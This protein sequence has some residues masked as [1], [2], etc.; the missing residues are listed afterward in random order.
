M[1]NTE[2]LNEY[3]KEIFGDHPTDRDLIKNF[4]LKQLIE[5]HRRLR[6]LNLEKQEA[7]LKAMDEGRNIGIKQGLKEINQ[8]YI[9]INDLPNKTLQEIAELILK[10]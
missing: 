8:E 1:T 3:A 10:G 5:S 9:S 4:D 7:F 2:L 6:S